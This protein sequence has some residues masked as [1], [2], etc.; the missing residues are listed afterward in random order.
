MKHKYRVGSVIQYEAF[1]GEIRT[2]TVAEVEHDIK[3]GLPG[4]SAVEP[5]WGYDYQIKRVIKY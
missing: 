4:F 2:V 1:G 3:N 5:Y